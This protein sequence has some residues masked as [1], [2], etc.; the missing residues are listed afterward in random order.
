MLLQLYIVLPSLASGKFKEEENNMTEIMEKQVCP[1]RLLDKIVE[2][3]MEERLFGVAYQ[4]TKETTEFDK[5]MKE[6]IDLS[7]SIR[8]EMGSGRNLFVRHEELSALCESVLLQ[9][10]YKRGFLDGVDFKSG[11]L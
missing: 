3:L 6:S 11:V 7:V 2:N 1:I 10:A 9:N 5:W 8:I 4:E